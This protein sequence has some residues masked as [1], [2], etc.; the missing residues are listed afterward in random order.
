MPESRINELLEL[1]HRVP[2]VRAKALD[3]A[4]H[5]LLEEIVSGGREHPRRERV[6]ALLVALDAL[7]AV[8]V[9]GPL[10]RR[11]QET[12]ALRT[13]AAAALGRVNDPAAEIALVEAVP[14]AIDITLRAKI[15]SSLCKVGTERSQ[16]TLQALAND[17]EE[18]VRKLGVFGLALIAHRNGTE[19]LQLPHGGGIANPPTQES[20]SSFTLT[21]P[22]EGLLRD[23]LPMLSDESY[24]VRVGSS[25]TFAID[26]DDYSLLCLDKEFFEE[27]LDQHLARRP[28]LVGVVARRSRIDA[29]FSTSRVILGG[30]LSG[31]SS[32]YVVAFRT[33][34]TRSHYGVGQ[35][36]NE[37]SGFEI[38]STEAERIAVHIRGVLSKGSLKLYSG[39]YSKKGEH[40]R[41]ARPRK[42]VLRGLGSHE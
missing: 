12:M 42:W 39:L 9:L 6:C 3:A 2:V 11:E 13:A 31:G 8:K 7:R 18:S 40:R 15:A 38:S 32:F 26:C 17:P 21:P 16:R 41:T 23:V 19:G 29:S 35:I 33:D 10:L 4:D 37:G 30:P 25:A 20:A 34:G 14:G 22:P 36:A 5:A 27:G 24:G 1:K 28:S